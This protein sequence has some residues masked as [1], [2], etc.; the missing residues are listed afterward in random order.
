MPKLG[1]YRP[2]VRKYRKGDKVT[3][4]Y[5]LETAIKTAE[6]MKQLNEAPQGFYVLAVSKEV[7]ACGRTAKECR[8]A[9][10]MVSK[11]QLT[12]NQWAAQTEAAYM[13][14]AK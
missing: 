10:E 8:N 6:K 3:S 7:L 12:F 2:T 4:K 13:K 5:D 1:Q 9:P 11:G 14:E